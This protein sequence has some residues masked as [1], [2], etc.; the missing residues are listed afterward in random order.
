MTLDFA[1]DSVAFPSDQG[2]FIAQN[3]E[4]TSLINACGNL[5]N[6]IAIT[7]AVSEG[8]GEGK[9]CTNTST[10]PLLVM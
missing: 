8:E 3:S 7:V 9:N 2:L 5:S 1:G 6:N 4:N 10:P